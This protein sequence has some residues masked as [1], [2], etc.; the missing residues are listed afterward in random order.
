MRMW[1]SIGAAACCVLGATAAAAEPM[2]FES[3]AIEVTDAAEGPPAPGDESG[4]FPLTPVSK[5]FLFKHGGELTGYSDAEAEAIRRY[6]DTDGAADVVLAG[7][8]E[9]ELAWNLPIVE[10]NGSTQ[11]YAFEDDGGSLTASIEADRITLSLNG[12][13]VVRRYDDGSTDIAVE[14]LSGKKTTPIVLEPRAY[15]DCRVIER[16]YETNILTYFVA[17]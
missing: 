13:L 17:P 8:A 11:T 12:A 3:T 4:L 2:C 14:T 16:V 7:I 6:L 1:L 5:V 9:G 10:T 15:G